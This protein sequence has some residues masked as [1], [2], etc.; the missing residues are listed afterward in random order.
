MYNEKR[1]IISRAALLTVLGLVLLT[2][3]AGAQ[4]L[5]ETRTSGSDCICHPTRKT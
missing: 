4:V 1:S 5:Y 2:Q 3:S